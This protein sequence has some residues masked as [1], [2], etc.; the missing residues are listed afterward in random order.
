M[1]PLSLQLLHPGA[2]MQWVVPCNVAVGEAMVDLVA[3]AVGDEFKVAW[4]GF[5]N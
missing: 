2:Q 1:S 5:S 4:F 3:A